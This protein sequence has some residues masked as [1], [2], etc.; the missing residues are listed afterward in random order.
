MVWQDAI[1][2]GGGSGSKPSS[3]R[4]LIDSEDGMGTG[5]IDGGHHNQLMCHQQEPRQ[6]L[7]DVGQSLHRAILL[8]SY[9]CLMNLPFFVMRLCSFVKVRVC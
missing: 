5:V 2:G 7:G 1:C 4:A 8:G 3:T 9:F 6:K